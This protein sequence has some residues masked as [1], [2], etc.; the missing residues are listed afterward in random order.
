[1]ARQLLGVERRPAPPPG[2][3]SCRSDDRRLALEVAG[4]T[5]HRVTT[6]FGGSGAVAKSSRPGARVGAF[7]AAARCRGDRG[8][9]SSGAT[10]GRLS[11]LLCLE[12]GGEG[13]VGLVLLA[14]PGEGLHRPPVRILDHDAAAP[15]G[16]QLADLL[17]D[18]GLGVARERRSS[19]RGRACARPP[20]RRP[21]R[22]A[23]PAIR[24]GRRALQTPTRIRLTASSAA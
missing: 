8:R 24:P 11:G 15:S 1:M 20:A 3:W 21:R 2:R 12:P 9:G 14:E 23:C 7:G 19:G 5:R 18:G 22:P 16:D 17:G 6:A 13:R 4:S 10:S